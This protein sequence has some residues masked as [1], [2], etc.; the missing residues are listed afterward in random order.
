MSRASTGFHRVRDFSHQVAVIALDLLFPPHCVHCQR[1]GSLLCSRCLLTL[2]WSR[3]RQ[4]EGL[5][6]VCV[7]VD[8][9]GAA[10]SAIHA[11]KYD[12]QT[13]LVDLL[14]S[15]LIRAMDENHWSP[16][17]VT[18]VPLHRKRQLERGYNQSVLLA[19]VVSERFGWPFSAE[20]IRRLRETRSQVSLNARERR[21]NV[22]GAFA[23]SP[24]L[25]RGKSVLV[26][27]DVLTTGATLVACAEALRQAGALRV[28][29]ATVAGAVYGDDGRAGASGA[30]V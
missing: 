30:S 10:S 24:E 9:S 22:Q 3:G 23:A 17:L 12:H 5:D 1:V 14:G 16:E 18:A 27:D 26:I 20:A 13:R 11:F 29:G 19:R 8:F 15:W 4:V 2:A 28:L 25:V 21:D 7:A 6:D